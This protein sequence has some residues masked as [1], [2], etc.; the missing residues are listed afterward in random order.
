MAPVL[1]AI[2]PSGTPDTGYTATGGKWV[3]RSMQMIVT[4]QLASCILMCL[5][6]GTL[7]RG[8][9][10]LSRLPLGFSPDHLSVIEAGPASREAG[11]SFSVGGEGD[12]PYAALTRSLLREADAALPD[13]QSIAAASCAPYGQTMRALRIQSLDLGSSTSGTSARFFLSAA[14]PSA[15]SRPWERLSIADADFLRI[16]FWMK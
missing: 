5:L 15:F 8:V 3:K 1:R 2:R 11:I 12:F 10:A 6:A 16:T 4:L 13:T 7:V 9:F 14:S